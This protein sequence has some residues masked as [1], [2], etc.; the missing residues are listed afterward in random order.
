MP[1][2]AVTTFAVAEA[3]LLG[4]VEDFA[5]IVT[6]PPTATVEVF[7]KVAEAPLAVWL[8]MVPQ[9]EVLQLSV[10]STPPEPV[11]LETMAVSVADRPG[12]DFC[13]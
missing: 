13:T 1:A 7:W 2:E 6:V 12:P 9:L 10:Q 4:S 5:V 3:D 8:E 11:S